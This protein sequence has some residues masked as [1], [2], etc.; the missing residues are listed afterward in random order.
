MTDR[1]VSVMITDR[2]LAAD[3]SMI[4]PERWTVRRPPA[5]PGGLTAPPVQSAV[6]GDNLL[7]NGKVSPFQN[8]QRG[9][10]RY[11]LLNACETRALTFTLWRLDPT[12]CGPAVQV[13]SDH[14]RLLYTVSAHCAPISAAFIWWRWT[15]A[16]SSPQS[17]D[18]WASR[19][20]APALSSR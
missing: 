3:G 2:T 6:F 10:Y 12:T 18:R 8:V 11:R 16:T 4:Y 14:L 15:E 13:R 1:D 17:R 9:K 5:V 7:V 19:K 20:S